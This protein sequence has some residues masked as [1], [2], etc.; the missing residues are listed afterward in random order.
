MA[1]VPSAPARGTAAPNKNA[2][3]PISSSVRALDGFVPD[4]FSTLLPISN[5]PHHNPS[6]GQSPL[7]VTEES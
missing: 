1:P 5:S 4:I 6:P 2:A 3:D 7:H